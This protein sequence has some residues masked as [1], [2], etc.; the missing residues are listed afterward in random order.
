MVTIHSPEAFRGAV[1]TEAGRQQ[2]LHINAAALAG[3]VVAIIVAQYA[4]ARSDIS[5]VK[6][7]IIKSAFTHYTV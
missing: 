4:A 7:K 6:R 2:S 5:S 1:D 3:G